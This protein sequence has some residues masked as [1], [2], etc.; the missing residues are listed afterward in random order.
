M[1]Q[2]SVSW[3]ITEMEPGMIRSYHGYQALESMIA[4]FSKV[5]H[6]SIRK[7]T[8]NC[9]FS[10]K[11]SIHIA[12]GSAKRETTCRLVIQSIPSVIDSQTAST[13]PVTC[14]RK[15]LT[16]SLMAVAMNGPQQFNGRC[17]SL[18]DCCQGGLSVKGLTVAEG[19]LPNAGVR[20]YLQPIT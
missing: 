2:V 20:K 1:I 11:E 8:S 4:V 16:C 13:Q 3:A 9:Y 7:L 19:L 10:R 14:F 5:Q 6:A 15:D 12:E 18:P 17:H